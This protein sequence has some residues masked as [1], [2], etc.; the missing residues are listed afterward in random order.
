MM[1]AIIKIS[2]KS[3]KKIAI[4]RAED[5]AL[6]KWCVQRVLLKTS[7]IVPKFATLVLD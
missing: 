4:A 6:R 2:S 3:K 1:S 5:A 7:L